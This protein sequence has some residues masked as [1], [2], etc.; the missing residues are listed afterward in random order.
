[1]N[2]KGNSAK[3]DLTTL[4]KDIHK[5]GEK[6]IVL[7]KKYQCKASRHESWVIGK[8]FGSTYRTGIGETKGPYS[9]DEEWKKERG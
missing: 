3:W 4:N 1:V 6:H 7:Y 5:T 2:F 9:V 8:P